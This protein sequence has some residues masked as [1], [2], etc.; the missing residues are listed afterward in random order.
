MAYGI[1]SGADGNLWFTEPG[2][3]RIATISPA[4]AISEWPPLVNLPAHQAVLA[5]D[6]NVWRTGKVRSTHSA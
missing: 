2:V 6:G 5:T 3:A 4:G 1:T